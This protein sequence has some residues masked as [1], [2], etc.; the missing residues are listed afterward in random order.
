MPSFVVY[1]IL[2]VQRFFSITHNFSTL[3]PT[4]RYEST[5]IST[6]NGYMV[7]IWS[8]YGH[9]CLVFLNSNV[10]GLNLPGPMGDTICRLLLSSSLL[11]WRSSTPRSG[12]SNAAFHP[13]FLHQSCRLASAEDRWRHEII[14]SCL[15][16]T[17]MGEIV[18]EFLGK[19]MMLS[20]QSFRGEACLLAIGYTSLFRGFIFSL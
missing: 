17:R 4:T 18:R 8:S 6:V 16:V 20:C 11:F 9:H 2:F 15:G 7:I 13:R 1:F 12:A 14:G 10:V 3:S 5:L 19:G